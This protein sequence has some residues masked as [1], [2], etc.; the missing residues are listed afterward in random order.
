MKKIFFCWILLLFSFLG[1]S[2]TFNVLVNQ[3]IPDDNTTVAFNLNVSGLPALINEN[4]GVESVCLNMTHTYCADMEIKLQAP[5]GTQTLLFS[6]IGGG[7]DD[8][9]NTCLAGS[10]PAIAAGAAPFTGSFQSMSVLGN[11]NNGQNPNGVWKLLC[12][13]MGAIDIGFLMNW[14]I[15][16]SNAPAQPFLFLSSNIP[17]VKLTSLNSAINNNTKVPVLMQIIDNGSGQI[18]YANQTNYAYEGKILAEWQG[19]SGPY[20]PKKNYDFDLIDSNGVKIDTVIIGL[21]SENDFIFKAEYLDHSLLKNTITY[22]FSRRMGT[23]APRTRPC[24][25]LLDGEYLGYYTLTE[26][27]KR[28]KNRVNIAN[29][30]PTDISGI[31]L[32]GGY[33]IEM[34]INGE[35]GAWN[36]NYAPINSATAGNIVEFK[37][38]DPKAVEILPLQAN[39]IHSFVDSFENALNAS[40][41]M[42]T[43]IGYTKFIDVSTFID[44]LIV[45]EFSVN[46]DS[47]GRSTFMYKEKATDGG[48]LKIGPPWDYDRA[49]DYGNINSAAGWVWLNTH[50]GWPFP[51]WWSKLY[52]DPNYKKKLACRWKTLRQDALKTS[53]FMYFIDSMAN[54]LNQASV[55]NFTVWNELGAQSYS[56]QINSL[57]SY[58]TTR[59]AWIDNELAPFS[60]YQINLNLPQDTTSC[61]DLSYDA[62][63]ANGSFLS[64][65][66]QPGPDSSLIYITSSGNYYLQVTDI[67]GCQKKDSIHV[68]IFQNSDTTLA[69]NSLTSYLLNGLNYTA[70]GTY[71]QTIL[72]KDGCDSLITLNLKIVTNENALLVFPNPTSDQVLVSLPE[73]FIGK[74]IS[75][76]DYTGRIVYDYTVISQDETLSLLDLAAGTYYLRIEGL[77]KLATIVKQ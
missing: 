61:T 25:I 60:N 32:T 33:I 19:F 2:Q 44:F 29:L 18:N 49:M 48:K 1:K 10:G 75:L 63:L 21:P 50:P 16:F 3:S 7:E 62:S 20:Y 55:R 74:N 77:H 67:Y 34:N 65:N 56:D 59:L 42:D 5:D 46:Y 24:E 39:Y 53:E 12:R 57:K 13:D 27:I 9:I 11:V 72:N 51:F 70:S 37:Y 52:S 40:T 58:L 14:Q 38:V 36:S 43:Q 8:F 41:F 45:N 73:E 22:E 31:N 71:Y 66:W 30:S 64:Y 76:Y 69:V 54:V 35:S 23:Y 4:F 47:Y 68:T 15:T 26:A 6:G 28:D 17:I